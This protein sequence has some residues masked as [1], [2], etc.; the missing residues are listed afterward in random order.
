MANR[1]GAHAAHPGALIGYDPVSDAA[2]WVK[3]ELA[4]AGIDVTINEMQGAPFTAAL[5]KHEHAFF[6]VPSWGSINNDPF[7]HAW[8]LL[9]DK[10]CNYTDYFNQEL[11][12]LITKY[13]VSADVDAR[14]TAS[15]RVQEIAVNE[16]AWVFLYQP[17][18]TH[19]TRQN[20]KGLIYYP[21]NPGTLRYRS[22]HKE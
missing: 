15:R 20:V 2:Q 9:R 21:T 22:L 3:S 19:I 17:D 18:A 14:N 4:K 12:D 11:D 1:F 5:Q 13:T 8:W 16:A 10:C 6:H 7:Y